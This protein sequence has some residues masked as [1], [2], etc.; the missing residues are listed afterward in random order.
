MQCPQA[1]ANLQP[2]E[3]KQQPGMFPSHHYDHH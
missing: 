2:Y 3:I 1:I